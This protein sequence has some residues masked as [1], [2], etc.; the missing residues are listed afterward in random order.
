MSG[1]RPGPKTNRTRKV[2]IALSLNKKEYT[3]AD[4]IK[5]LA[6]F[7][8][9]TPFK[10][11]GVRFHF[12]IERTVQ[13]HEQGR[14]QVGTHQHRRYETYT[15]TR[16]KTETLLERRT[17]F[18]GNKRGDTSGGSNALVLLTCQTYKFPI[19]EIQLTRDLPAAVESWE[20]TVRYLMRVY[21]DRP[22]KSDP[23]LEVIIPVC[24]PPT[25]T[26]V[27]HI[28][29]VEPQRAHS[30]PQ[31]HVHHPPPQ[32]HP[33]P[34]QY[35]APPSASYGAPP[36]SYASSGAYPSQVHDGYA[37][38]SHPPPSAYPAASMPALSYQYSQPPPSHYGGA[39]PPG[40]GGPPPGYAPA[41]AAQPPPA[42]GSPAAYPPSS[43][44]SSSSS[45]SSRQPVPSPHSSGSGL[46]PSLPPSDQASAPPPSYN[47]HYRPQ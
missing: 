38:G 29:R 13:W 11:R 30:M 20:T 24:D 25:Q 47:P 28:H 23:A 42:Y 8:V 37:H 1:V 14:R 10:C 21:I 18:L 26:V 35:Y 3:T 17:T 22:L 36:P 9:K 6:S 33:P 40:Y 41:Y 2:E 16:K 34:Q 15:Y 31:P 32:A 27:T 44:P 4:V 46:Y 45:M 5:G 39:P 43:A 19:P 12:R 7:R